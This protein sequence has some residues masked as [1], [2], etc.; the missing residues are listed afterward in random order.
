[1]T[2]VVQKLKMKQYI[3]YFTLR[4]PEWETSRFG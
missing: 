1:M 3:L 2:K 4:L